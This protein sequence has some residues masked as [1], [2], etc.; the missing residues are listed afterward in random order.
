MTDAVLEEF[1]LDNAD[2]TISHRSRPR[3]FFHD[4][5]EA[6]DALKEVSREIHESMTAERQEILRERMRKALRWM[7]DNTDDWLPLSLSYK[8]DG[9]C[10]AIEHCYVISDIADG[11]E[12]MAAATSVELDAA[13]QELTAKDDEE[14]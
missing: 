7:A 8:E 11:E 3:E 6:E 10:L 9:T 12:L 1:E 4:N 2:V 14:V 13:I 5:R